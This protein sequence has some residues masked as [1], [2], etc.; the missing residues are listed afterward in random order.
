M[1]GRVHCWLRFF[2]CRR[3]R[4]FGWYVRNI[5]NYSLIYGSVGTSIALLIWMY[6]IAAIGLY[7]CAFNAE[8][9][10]SFLDKP[11]IPPGV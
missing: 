3:Q 5:T 9:E 1:F 11:A 8:C 6:L 4:R 7:G 10:R 2:G